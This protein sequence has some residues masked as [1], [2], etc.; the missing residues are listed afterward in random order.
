PN[1]LW[2]RRVA[3]FHRIRGATDI[4]GRSGRWIGGVCGASPPSV[5][6]VSGRRLRRL[7]NQQAGAQ[8][9]HH[10]VIEE[11]APATVPKS[12]A[13]GEEGFGTRACGALLNQQGGA[14]AAHP[15][16]RAARI[17]NPQGPPGQFARGRAASAP[18]SGVPKRCAVIDTA[19]SR[20][21]GSNST[22]PDSVTSSA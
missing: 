14:Y 8:T 18:G 10:L 12:P 2:F 16:G 15:D 21:N 19:C 5:R 20:R 13:L 4:S 22:R 3:L 7:L 11:V 17:L 1:M 9:R 6:G